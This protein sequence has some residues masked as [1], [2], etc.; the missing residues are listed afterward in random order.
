MSDPETRKRLARFHRDHRP[1]SP[2]E[3]TAFIQG[4]QNEVGADP[5]ADRR[6]KVRAYRSSG[7]LFEQPRVLDQRIAVGHAGDEIADPAQAAG[8][9]AGL[10]ALRPVRRQ[11]AGMLARSAQNRSQTTVS[12]SPMMRMTRSCRYMR[13]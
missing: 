10:G 12:A 13:G 9:V 7:V 8:I 5:Q 2:A 6:G 4:E 3:T 11:V 1:M